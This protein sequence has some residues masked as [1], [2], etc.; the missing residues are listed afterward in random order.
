[1]LRI[2][3]TLALVHA[4]VLV[5]AAIV[6]LAEA[7]PDDAAIHMARREHEECLRA[8][9]AEADALMAWRPG[10]GAAPQAARACGLLQ[11]PGWNMGLVTLAAQAGVGALLFALLGL[12]AR[13]QATALAHAE[14]AARHRCWLADKL[15]AI[16]KAMRLSS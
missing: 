16:E 11:P 13:G 7:K 14:E 12:L 4:A 15:A 5:V 1:M 6:L 9:R 8:Q 10:R 3:G 2:V